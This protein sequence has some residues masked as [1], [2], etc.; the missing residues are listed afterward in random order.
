M[1]DCHGD[2]L[3]LCKVLKIS[4]AWGMYLITPGPQVPTTNQKEKKRKK[5]KTNTR[6]GGPNNQ[7]TLIQMSEVPE[8]ERL[9]NK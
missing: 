2:Y 7:L 3:G 1:T 9:R 8:T 5:E 6:E 4:G